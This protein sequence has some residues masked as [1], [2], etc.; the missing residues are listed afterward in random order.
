MAE[1]ALK[2]RLR[3]DLNAARKSR[4]RP[5]TLLLTTLLADVRNR[6]IE[7]G[8]EL[9][10]DEV[11]EVLQRAVKRRRESADLMKSRPELA[12][13]ETW[14]AGVLESYLPEALSD[15]EIRGIVRS[16][17]EQGAD[18]IGAVMKAV[19]PQVKGRA[20]GKR[21]NAIAQEELRGSGGGGGGT[22]GRAP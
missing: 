16:A 7:L 13:R 4:D 10:D 1:S 14:E 17:I 3:S 19:M 15:E 20:D 21:V 5:R 9:S 22:G 6:E 18:S 8:H 2:A 11:V 12:E